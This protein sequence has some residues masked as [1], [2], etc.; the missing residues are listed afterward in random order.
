MTFW[1]LL[2]GGIGS[3]K[4]TVSE[5]FASLGVPVIDTDIISRKLTG[6]S[7]LAIAAIKERFGEQAIDSCNALNRDWMR[8]KVFEDAVARERLESI[9]HPLIFE[10][11]LE[12]RSKINAL[13]GLIVVPLFSQDSIYRTIIDRVLVVDVDKQIQRK[14]VYQRGGLSWDEV[15]RVIAIQ[16][17][18]ELR[19]NLADDIV[20][21][22]D[23]LGSLLRE[24]KLLHSKYLK[25]F[26]QERRFE[27]AT[28]SN[29]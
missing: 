5:A 7:G 29:T 22:N 19:L 13:Y 14:R 20:T 11:V 10:E 28:I 9:L 21:N 23:D 8:K 26:S 16:L 17:S 24:V 15:D 1:V 25:L 6:P 12:L 27:P 2:T 18:R 4:T 3:G